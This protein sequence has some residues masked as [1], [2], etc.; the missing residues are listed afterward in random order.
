MEFYAS[1]EDWFAAQSAAGCRI[2]TVRL[3]VGENEFVYT[4]VEVSEQK[5]ART[6]VDTWALVTK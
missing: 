6:A 4:P 3:H 1:L 2:W 5:A